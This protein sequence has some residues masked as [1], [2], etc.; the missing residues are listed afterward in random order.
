MTYAHRAAC[1][2]HAARRA[3][4]RGLELSPDDLDRLA[5][6]L[7]TLRPMYER[8]GQTR[9]QLRL[10]LNRRRLFV[11]YDTALRVVVT[12]GHATRPPMYRNG[13]RPNQRRHANDWL[14]DI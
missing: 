7:E 4:Q 3:A 12:V 14:A 1:Q 5:S 6:V 9:Y 2:Y 11:V 8:P 10:R 13:P